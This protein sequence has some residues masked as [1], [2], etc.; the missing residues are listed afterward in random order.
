M[1]KIHRY[2]SLLL[3]FGAHPQISGTTGLVSKKKKWPYKGNLHRRKF[4]DQQKTKLK[5]KLHV[6]S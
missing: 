3:S 1:G 6:L 5:M 2:F 4:Q